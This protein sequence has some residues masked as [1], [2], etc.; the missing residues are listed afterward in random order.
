MGRQVLADVCAHAQQDAPCE[1]CGL[2]IGNRE[3]IVEA[4]PARNDRSGL[5][6]YL[7]NPED[8]FRA[9]RKARRA[10]LAV[11]GAYHSHPASGPVPSATDLAEA[12]DTELLHVIVSLTTRPPSVRGFRY[13]GREFVPVELRVD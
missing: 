8:H 7:I 1:C 2:L 9:I 13:T 12:N 4:F 10:G 5:S 11:I 3:A 6:R